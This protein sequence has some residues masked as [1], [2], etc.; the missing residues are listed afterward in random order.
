MAVATYLSAMVR[1]RV[2]AQALLMVIAGAALACAQAP[3]APRT[4]LPLYRY[5]LLGIYDDQNGEPI[6]GVEVL[7]VTT[8]LGS[9]TSKTGTLSLF[10]LPDGGAVVRIRKLGY[11]VR[12]SPISISPADTTPLTLTLSRAQTLATVVTRGSAPN[13]IPPKLR[14]FE[15][16]RRNSATGHFIA[17]SVLRAEEG[18]TLASVLR[19]HVPGVMI[20]DKAHSNFLMRSPRCSNGGPPD[21]YIDGVPLAHVPTIVLGPKRGGETPPIDLSLFD[22]SSFAG[23]EYY[24]DDTGLPI[25]FNHTSQ[26]CGALLLWTR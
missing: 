24:P 26:S 19:G 25:E 20:S 23:V 9:L 3:P 4:H 18:R 15:E 16:R 21:V 12:V 22:V 13:A 10:F 11:E 7:D 8:G 14:D 6:E 17:D 5:R 1:R 2:A